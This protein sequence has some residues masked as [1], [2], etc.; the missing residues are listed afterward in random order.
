MNIRYIALLLSLCMFHAELGFSQSKLTQ[1]EAEERFGQV[2][3]V[4]YDLYLDITGAKTFSG[5]STLTFDLKSVEAPLRIDF[6]QGTVSAVLF[7]GK[8]IAYTYDQQA[9][10]IKPKDLKIGKAVIKVAYTH[11]FD[12]DGDGLYRFV[13]PEDQRVYVWTQFEA[14]AANQMFPSFDQPDLKAKFKLRVLAPKNW[15]V[16]SAVREDALNTQPKGKLWNF[17]ESLPISTYVFSL[18][19]GPWKIW[20]DSKFRIPLRL[21]ARQSLAPYVK[22]EEW[23]DWTRF[24]F[25][26]FEKTFGTPYPFGKYD[27]LLVPD[28]VAGAMENVGAVTFNER[29]APRG[30]RSARQQERTFNTLLHEMAHMWF[31]DLVTMKWW[32]D[33][34]LNESFASYAA[35]HALATHPDYGHAW[36]SFHSDKSSG[37]FADQLPSTHPIVG[38]IADTQVA[39]SVFDGITYGKGASWLKLLVF[40]VGEDKF[41]AGLKDY[42]KK[43]QYGNTTVDDLL[44]ALEDKD[45]RKTQ[46]FAK[47]WLHTAG[48]NRV[49]VQ[50]VCSKESRLTALEIEQTSPEKLDQLRPHSMNVAIYLDPGER[51]QWAAKRVIRVDY[52]GAKTTVPVSESLE[53]PTL[54]FPN[55]TDDDY[56][57]VQFPSDAF[58]KLKTDLPRLADPMHRAIFW[59]SIAWAIED[60][61]MP[62]EDAI[63]LTAQVLPLEK[64]FAVLGHI[65]R[66][67]RF[68]IVERLEDFQD[69]DLRIRLAKPI[70]D[71]MEK[72]L[73]DTKTAKDFRLSAFD[74]HIAFLNL[75]EDRDSLVR[76]FEGK[77]KFPELKLDQPKKWAI[78]KAL[79]E[80]GDTRAE[81]LAKAEKDKSAE[82][83]L[84]KRSIAASLAPYSEKLKIIEEIIKPNT[85]TSRA[86]ARASLGAIFPAQQ[87]DARQKFRETYIKGLSAVRSHKQ[88]YIQVVY[89][90][91]LLPSGCDEK[92]EALFAEVYKIEWPATIKTDVIE[93]EY[94]LRLCRSI[95]ANALSK[96]Q[97]KG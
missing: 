18:H 73:I 9:I 25:D 92:D 42:F 41:F 49:K 34:W 21:M 74:S 44:S 2:S 8:K 3:G 36:V 29:S 11:A 27:Q 66:F 17:P 97:A 84:A 55:A 35:A 24:G 67:M 4:G 38:D 7:N 60:G 12:K 52:D 31:G 53:C 62:L 45:S 85:Q 37:Y 20:E 86:E 33:L 94:G 80:L 32:N 39:E 71:A 30:D 72:I 93:R 89:V 56:V 95:R 76:I 64:D 96:P 87:S 28:F 63:T 69:R 58:L 91:S 78:L 75:R 10:Y 6:Y 47:P 13:D 26:Y 46:D 1:K 70:D 81:T 22:A 68:S 23:L 57:R 51:E 14:F 77:T 90:L 43:H 19:A 40:R 16:V 88:E 5:E 50:A 61:E 15:T 83:E 79:A 54:V 82:A 65:E 59:D 48:L